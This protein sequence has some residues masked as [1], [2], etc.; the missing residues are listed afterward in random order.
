MTI[1]DLLK[2]LFSIQAEKIKE[3]IENTKK[4]LSDTIN[5]SV[6]K[7]NDV[8]KKIKDIDGILN[9]KIDKTDFENK[10]GNF[11]K[12]ISQFEEKIKN[13]EK[14]NNDFKSFKD[15]FE[16]NNELKNKQLQLLESMLGLDEID[17]SKIDEVKDP[18]DLDKAL[19]DNKLRFTKPSIYDILQNNFEKIKDYIKFKKSLDNSDNSS[20]SD[21]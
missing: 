20:N 16:K 4:D 9:Q 5:I 2:E 3:I 12:T 11:E 14:L 6:E 1:V 10:F 19:K 7:I 21:N 17:E 15:Q 18:E 8:T 13:L